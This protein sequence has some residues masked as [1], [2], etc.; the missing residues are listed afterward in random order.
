MLQDDSRS[1]RLRALAILSVL[2]SLGVAYFALKSDLPIRAKV[3]VVQTAAATQKPQSLRMHP[4][5][6]PHETSTMQQKNTSE[7]DQLNALR[8]SFGRGV[9]LKQVERARSD[10]QAFVSQLDVWVHR[11]CNGEVEA[12]A[13]LAL[14]VGGAAPAVRDEVTSACVR[15]GLDAKTIQAMRDD[16]D[17]WWK[18]AAKSDE[19]ASLAYARQLL[20]RATLVSDAARQNEA[21]VMMEQLMDK[22]VVEAF[23]EMGGYAA[24]GAFGAETQSMASAYL[25]AGALL[26]PE[27]SF[28]N[29]A[30]NVLEPLRAGDRLTVVS[31]AK[32]ILVRVRGHRSG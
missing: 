18:Q 26:D 4:S 11:A 17:Y 21:R 29:I 10:V 27:R 15:Q 19:H 25:L 1:F 3:V 7:I 31:H 22:G 30:Q 20:L 9:T 8:T 5:P 32:T 2:F 6:L 16:S 12:T 28:E 24:S 14:F 23:T 13:R